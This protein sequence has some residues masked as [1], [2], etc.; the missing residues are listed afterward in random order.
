MFF[1]GG[2]TV[3]TPIQ[4]RDVV[5][6]PPH[7][8]IPERVLA[9]SHQEDYRDTAKLTGGWKFGVPTAGYRNGGVG[10]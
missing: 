5:D 10:V 6:D 8:Q 4:V 9:K 3:S 1:K 2:G 7:G